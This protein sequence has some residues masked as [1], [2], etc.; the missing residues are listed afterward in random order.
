MPHKSSFFT[1]QNLRCEGDFAK[2]AA[3]L[4]LSCLR[5]LS[6]NRVYEDV[7]FYLHTSLAS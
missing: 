6:F 7:I 3:Y 4:I 2:A 5:R 1:A